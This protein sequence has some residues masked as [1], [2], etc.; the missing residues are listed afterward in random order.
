MWGLCVIKHLGSIATLAGSGPASSSWGRAPQGWES[1][2]PSS[3]M[4]I[5]SRKAGYVALAAASDA[6]AAP[7]ET[8]SQQGGERRHGPPLRAS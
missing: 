5:S 3:V 6:D 4:T 7:T 8:W 1:A 2:T